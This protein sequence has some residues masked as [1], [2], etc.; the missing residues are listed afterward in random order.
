MG[1]SE[2][3]RLVVDVGYYSC[4]PGGSE[5]YTESILR[6]KGFFWDISDFERIGKP[7]VETQIPRRRL[8]TT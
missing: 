2:E 8:A 5:R 3:F 6:I 4:Q 1:I 7:S